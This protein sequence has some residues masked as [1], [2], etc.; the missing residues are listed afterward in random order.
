[1]CGIFPIKNGDGAHSDW[2]V[3]HCI[4][5]NLYFLYESVGYTSIHF[6]QFKNPVHNFTEQKKNVS[7]SYL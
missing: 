1:M 2:W 4:P 3:K 5:D 6:C 7:K